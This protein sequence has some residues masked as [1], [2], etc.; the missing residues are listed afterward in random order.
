MILNS[1]VVRLLWLVVTTPPPDMP[2]ED[3]RQIA[4]SPEPPN[5]PGY[6]AALRK[7]HQLTAKTSRF[8]WF[9]EASRLCAE[10]LVRLARHSTETREQV[11]RTVEERE[12]QAATSAL[13]REE[14]RSSTTSWPE[15]LGM[16][17]TR[18]LHA[19]AAAARGGAVEYLI[20]A[21]EAAP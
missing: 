13:L 17:C 5:G 18:T 16:Q 12:A 2:S 11:V 19:T 1:N 20:E 9:A 21:A 8:D 10:S 7:H 3:E 15:L 14:L 6:R 4:G